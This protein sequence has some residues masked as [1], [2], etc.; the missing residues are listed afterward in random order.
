M[1]EEAAA[2]A[3]GGML[4][5]EHFVVEN[6]FD[7]DSGDGGMIHTAIEEDLIGARIVAAELAAPT[8]GA[9]AD[10]GAPQTSR[11]VFFV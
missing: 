9:P 5:V 10:V 7:R 8:A 4:D 11:K 6:V 3:A 2:G 1:G